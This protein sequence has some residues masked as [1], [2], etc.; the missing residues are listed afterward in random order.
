MPVVD[1]KQLQKEAEKKEKD[2]PSIKV[3]KIDGKNYFQGSYIEDYFDDYGECISANEAQARKEL[4][5]KLGLNEEGQSPEQ[6]ERI[7]KIKK[8]V[9]QKNELLEQVN[10]IDIKIAIINRG[11][12][13]GSFSDDD[14]ESVDTKK[15]K[16][17][18]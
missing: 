4:Y 3:V 17:R 6:V 8:L 12:K 7:K 13:P 11:E 5:K 1:L 18:K 15:K 14:D 16:K 9:D 2:N 10:Q